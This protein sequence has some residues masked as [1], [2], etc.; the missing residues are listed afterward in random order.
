MH[1]NDLPYVGF[2]IFGLEN[3]TK[4]QKLEK[5]FPLGSKRLEIEELPLSA[6]YLVKEEDRIYNLS[7]GSYFNS[8]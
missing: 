3:V 6:L 1:F 2:K 7:S 4:M 5:I 8:N